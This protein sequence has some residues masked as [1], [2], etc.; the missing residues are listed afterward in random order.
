MDRDS[1]NPVHRVMS[2]RR[3]LA[4]AGTGAAGLTAAALIG[5]S[6]KSQP[7]SSASI[8]T[9]VPA[10][11]GKPKSGGTLKFAQRNNPDSL[12]PYKALA[13]TAG[14]HNASMV[15]SQLF[16]NELGDGKAASGKVEGDLAEKW[17]QPDPLTLVIHL[18]Q[19]AKF[20]QKDPLNG[21]KVTAEDVVE[22]WKYYAKTSTYRT[23]LSN[24]ANPDAAITGME[25]IDPATVRVKLK[26]VDA[27]T[28]PTMANGFWVMPV[29]GITGKIDLT[30]EPRGS[31]PFLFDSYKSSVSLAY[32]RNPNWFRSGGS[33]PYFDAVNMPII[34]EQAQLEAQFRAKNLH[35]A[36]V[37]QE[38][39]PIFAKELKGTE[40]VIGSPVSRSHLGGFSYLPGQPWHDVRVR[41]ALSMTIDRDVMAKVL[42]APDSFAQFGVKLTT[43]WNAP[44]G[45]AYGAFWL[46]PKSSSFGP[47]AA[48]LQHNVPEA[49]KMLAAAGFTS[50]KP[51]EFDYVYAGSAFGADFP[52]RVEIQQSMMKDAGIKVNAIAV[53]YTTDYIPN[54]LRS[55]AAFK[56][57][58]VEAAVHYYPGGA[59]G[60]PLGAFYFQHLSSTGSS[61]QTGKKFPELDAMA[62]KQQ[63]VTNFDERI[64]GIHELN[65]WATDNMVV[66]PA[67]PATETVDLVWK[68]LR[69]P[70][71]YRAW[72]GLYPSLDILP[73][74]WFEE[75]I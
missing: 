38:N 68:A 31:G 12:D 50:A 3:A 16:I 74:S 65:R 46:D 40:V 54:Y 33:R 43:R 66:L 41:R 24:A 30:K 61:S 20:D 71:Q 45:G 53:D 25:V 14:P 60:D 22:T 15:Y 64:A 26:F 36:A 59:G 17:E 56:G 34:P 32:K 37:S 1:N 52:Q 8:A 73:E 75:Q 2:R 7:A 62:R 42:Y 21:R 72:T 13:S 55:K 57:K 29:E 63:Q 69:G 27:T 10:G 44:L 11:S 70:G 28:I 67:G 23:Q 39:I 48:Y 49:V 9:A 51:L 5:C 6:S 19:A 58:K 47:A 35:F 4:L 18:N